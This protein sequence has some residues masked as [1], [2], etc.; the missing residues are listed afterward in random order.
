MSLCLF[1][2]LLSLKGVLQLS[3]YRSAVIWLCSPRLVCIWNALHRVMFWVLDS[4]RP[5]PETVEQE[6]EGCL[7][8]VAVGTGLWRFSLQE[9]G[10]FSVSRSAVK[11]AASIT[12]LSCC[13]HCVFPT[14]MGGGILK[15]EPRETVPLLRCL[16]RVCGYSNAEGTSTDN[17]SVV[18]L[19]LFSL[20]VW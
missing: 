18:N 16:C 2:S 9:V 4:R 1:R 7:Q 3:G 20:G 15:H 19:T 11:W 17:I 6:D 14:V 10:S 12:C 8:E 13:E 5:A